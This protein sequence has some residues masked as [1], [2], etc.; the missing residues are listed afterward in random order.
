MSRDVKR[1]VRQMLRLLC[2]PAPPETRI[3]KLRE[4]AKCLQAHVVQ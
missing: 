2:S 1:Q 4:H 3:D